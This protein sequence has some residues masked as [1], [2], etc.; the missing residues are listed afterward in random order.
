MKFD[1]KKEFLKD[2]DFLINTTFNNNDT[3]KLEV[4]HRM[5]A[6]IE[7]K[8]LFLSLIIKEI[9]DEKAANNKT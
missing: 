3:S 2:L 6:L 4:I 5:R 7:V 8:E 9:E 1:I